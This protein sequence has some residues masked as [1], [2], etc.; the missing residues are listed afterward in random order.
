MH[1]N[2]SQV[3]LLIQSETKELGIRLS[4][5]AVCKPHPLLHWASRNMDNFKGE[6]KQTIA[7]CCSSSLGC[8][9]VPVCALRIV[10]GFFL[11]LQFGSL[12]VKLT[13]LY[14]LVGSSSVTCNGS[15]YTAS[16]L[17][18]SAAWCWTAIPPPRLLLWNPWGSLSRCPSWPI[19][20]S[21]FLETL[22]PFPVAETDWTSFSFAP[23]LTFCV[24]VGVCVCVSLS[25]S[26]F[27]HFS[28]YFYSLFLAKKVP[29]KEL[30]HDTRHSSIFFFHDLLLQL[31]F[32]NSGR[33]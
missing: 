4:S 3:P 11:E 8:W 19:R 13:A 6:K 7:T 21:S 23:C 29:G 17:P 10:R 30:G 1:R 14:A 5:P 16:L 20:L 27:L 9:R 33:R 24:R 12:G 2:R 32:K 18:L 31:N 15:R 22:S 25:L 26:C 28:P